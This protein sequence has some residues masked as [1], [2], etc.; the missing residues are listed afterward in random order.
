[1]ELVGEGALR[2]R[3]VIDLGVPL[4]RGR[5]L[6]FG[7]QPQ[8][9][10][11]KYEKLPI[12]CF[13]CGRIV[14]DRQGCPNRKSQKIHG[15]DGEKHWGTWIRAETREGGRPVRNNAGGWFSSPTASADSPGGRKEAQPEQFNGDRGS[16]ADSQGVQRGTDEPG[17]TEGT[18]GVRLQQ[19][20]YSPDS[21][22]NT[23]GDSSVSSHS[24]RNHEGTSVQTVTE[25]VGRQSINDGPLLPNAVSLGS[26]EK[27][28][29][30]GP[31]CVAGLQGP[32]T[33]AFNDET[34]FKGTDLKQKGVVSNKKIRGSSLRGWK[35]NA[36]T[37]QSA[38]PIQTLIRG[39]KRNAL[40]LG[41]DEIE[42]PAGGFKRGRKNDGIDWDEPIELAEAVLQLRQQP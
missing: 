28:N 22:G 33:G 20:G 10:S 12:V 17:K 23:W 37:R 35:R 39:N 11:F 2:L 30:E 4:E 41:E 6:V 40:A 34:A 26:F 16:E 7:G 36:R 1:M 42:D 38:T 32:M 14:H 5:E 3:V 31:V 9:V 13:Q 19:N 24:R 21:Q 8:W 27:M 25:L 29:V 15:E 18:L